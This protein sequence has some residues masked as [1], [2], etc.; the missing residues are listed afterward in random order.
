MRATQAT[1]LPFN[2]NLEGTV[3]RLEP[4]NSAHV[5]ALKELAFGYPEVFSLTSTPSNEAQAHAYFGKAL[6][7]RAQG[8]GHPVAV[9]MQRSG[10]VVGMSRLS[11]VDFGHRRCELGFSWYDPSLFRSGVNLESKLLL[12]RLAFDTLALHR[13]QIHTDTRNLRSQRAIEA[14]GARQEGVLRRHQVAADGYVR[15]TVVYSITDL[16]WPLVSERLTDKLAAK[17]SSAVT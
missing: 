8:T 2:Q 6:R 12:L 13:V 1:A 15:D 11:E 17:L 9:V 10:K 5:P 3:V 14:L 7:Q 4:F 16:D